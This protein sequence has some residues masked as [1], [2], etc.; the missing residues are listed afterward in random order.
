MK[1]GLGLLAAVA[2]LLT[3]TVAGCGS[4]GDDDSCLSVTGACQEP[5][6]IRC[7]PAGNGVQQCLEDPV[8][9]GCSSWVT[10]DAC[11]EHQSCV[12]AEQGCR[13]ANECSVEGRTR[14]GGEVIQSCA[15]D[16]DGCL[17][18]RDGQD[19]AALDNHHCDDNTEPAT[20]LEGCTDRC[21][22]GQTRCS[23]TLIQDCSLVGECYFWTDLDDC[24]SGGQICS[25]ASG[26]AGCYDPCSDDCP[27]A[28]ADRC[29]GALVEVCSLR[30]DGCNDWLTSDD[31]GAS[32]QICSAA[33]GAAGCY[34]P[35]SDAC[36][37]AGEIRCD[38]D[39]VQTC[40]LEANGCLNWLG[41][42]DCPGE[43]LIC[44]DYIDPPGCAVPCEHEC[45]AVDETRCNADATDVEI[46]GQGLDGCNDW[47]ALTNCSGDGLVCWDSGCV[48]PCV[49][50]CDTPGASQCDPGNA[51]VQVCQFD[52][53]DGCNDLID[54]PCAD[55]TP[56]CDVVGGQ[57]QCVCVDECDT[58]GG[59]CT[60][61]VPVNCV[62][63]QDGCHDLITASS[64]TPVACR[65]DGGTA[66]CLSGCSQIVYQAL[67]ADNPQSAL[68]QDFEAAF[69][70]LDSFAADDFT[71]ASSTTISTIWTNDRTVGTDFS[72]ATAVHYAIYANAGGLPAG[73]PVYAGAPLWSISL[74]P[75]DPQ[76]T[77][78]GNDVVLD[79]AS[80]LTLGAGTYWFTMWLAMDS[81]G[82]TRLHTWYM[83][84][85]T[86]GYDAMAYARQN[87]VWLSLPD[88]GAT[89]Q[90]MTFG[91][92]NCP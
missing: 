4:S 9:V 26:Q 22:A 1:I 64:C 92:S 56:A 30:D 8:V 88:N 67:A 85:T 24:A 90:D 70:A 16:V 43:G 45:P 7:A 51:I 27:T 17:Y 76:L 29:V 62:V 32:G 84:D 36:Q 78:A 71:L 57:A 83:S 74:A 79:L 87:G 35:C 65:V 19:C 28:G 3:W 33:S 46:C 21:A 25:A 23:G 72:A 50:E 52:D 80:P 59:V 34:D 54:S 37:A 73:V 89:H 49:D 61:N 40:T 15:R 53:T 42:R 68:A 6:E 60:G 14:C 41:T 38:G 91:L 10:T 63:G 44:A 82:G 86:N 47:V 13:C 66:D 2:A 58:P 39:W 55:P 11:G 20:C 18:W 12:S 77:I 69:D 5:G 48:A 75:S 31:C 81:A